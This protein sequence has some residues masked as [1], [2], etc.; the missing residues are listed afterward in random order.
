MQAD[1]RNTIVILEDSQGLQ[2]ANQAAGGVFDLRRPNIRWATHS[3][4]LIELLTRQGIAPLVLDESVSQ[5]EADAVG[6]AA[7]DA[8][9]AIASYLDAEVTGWPLGLRAGHPL[10]YVMHRT[11]TSYFYKAFLL[12]R[13]IEH[14]AAGTRIV[15]VGWDQASPVAG[16]NTMPNRF[17]TL[18]AVLASGLGLEVLRHK[19]VAPSGAM[20]TGDYLR[21][22]LWSRVTTVMNAPVA[23]MVYRLWGQ[24]LDGRPIALNR[25][26]AKLA[27]AIM[28]SNEL[29]EDTLLSLLRRG[30]LVFQAPPLPRNA[31]PVDGDSNEQAL[32]AELRGIALK[33]ASTLPVQSVA[34]FEVAAAEVAAR[35]V[36]A[37]RYG[38]TIA[39]A[40]P[41]YIERLRAKAESKPLALLSNG[42]SGGADRLLRD[43]LHTCNIPVVIAEHGVAPGLSTLH[44]AILER[45]RVEDCEA[46]IFWTPLQL[47]HAVELTG[48][49]PAQATVSGAPKRLRTIGLHTLQRYIVRRSLKAD[50]RL[51]A[52]CTGLYPNN[53]QFLPHYWR[54]SEYHRIR[55]EVLDSVLGG[56]DCQVL[57]KLYPTYRYTDPDPLSDPAYLP[58]NVRVEQFA[59]FRSLRAA[60]DVLMIDGPGSILG[61]SWGTPIP[62]IFLETGMYTLR[63][64]VR[65]QF[66]E[67]VFYV[68]VRRP[69]WQSELRELLLLPAGE[70]ARLYALKAERRRE[71]GRYC[72]LGPEG[73]PAGRAADFIIGKALG[74]DCVTT[75]RINDKAGRSHSYGAIKL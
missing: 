69:G 66:E 8:S 65:A 50:R 3:P 68:D 42:M 10:R 30:A 29:V 17:D 18:F 74:S 73:S 63:D 5:A 13:L 54:D 24:L 44:H 59:D 31:G 70:M 45:E 71:V 49:S 72:I 9:R 51:L 60:A 47:D 61:W 6:Y 12:A 1:E 26:R 19:S 52:W 28:E 37:V 57:L 21:P 27:I 40:L 75:D 38:A 22:S 20:E 14:S 41:G 39:D 67:A 32:T 53:M 35:I 46:T 34:P 4:Y 58:A 15:A 56:L 33:F 48:L 23:S 16:Y 36:K 64:S 55:R 43:A 25:G 2:A 62:M 11:L 7:L